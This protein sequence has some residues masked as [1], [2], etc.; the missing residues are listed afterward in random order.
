MMKFFKTIVWMMATAIACTT[1][2]AC[3]SDNYEPVKPFTTDPVELNKLYAYG[4]DPSATPSRS[5]RCR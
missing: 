2:T 3:S 5:T 4:I 1:V